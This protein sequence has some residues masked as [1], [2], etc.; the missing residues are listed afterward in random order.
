M[1]LNRKQIGNIYRPQGPK[2]ILV[3]QPFTPGAGSNILIAGPQI[4]L[5][6]PIE[7]FRIVLKLRDV[8]A[9]A[10]MTSVNPLGYLNLLNRIFITGKNSRASGNV[11]LWDIDAA[12]LA[13]IQS[14]IQLRP[15]VYNGVSAA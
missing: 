2:A 13:L 15:F 4:D 12:S 8:I 14:T 9:T 3:G 1:A 5:S 6:V 7:G 11:N 10:A